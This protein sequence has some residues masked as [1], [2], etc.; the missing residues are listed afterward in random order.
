[1]ATSIEG[2]NGHVAAWRLH[3]CRHA[4]SS[5]VATSE[6]ITSLAYQPPW[7]F[8]PPIACAPPTCVK[9]TATRRGSSRR[10]S[11]STEGSAMAEYARIAQRSFGEAENAPAADFARRANLHLAL[12]GGFAEELPVASR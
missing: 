9:S 8:M 7:P 10:R 12:G 3:G 2:C 5:R 11:P 6:E 1:M 4:S